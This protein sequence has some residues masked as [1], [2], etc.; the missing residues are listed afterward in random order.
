MRAHF[1]SDIFRGGLF[2][3][4]A[5]AWFA[6]LKAG[7][8]TPKLDGKYKRWLAANPA[9]EVAFE[10]QELAWELAG[11]LAKDDEIAVL[12]AEA[13][14][15]ARH[16]PKRA[17]RSRRLYLLSAVAAT[18]AV[19]TIGASVYLRLQSQT[20]QYTTAIGELRTVVLPDQSRM[21]LNTSTRVRVIYSRGERRVQLDQGEA[22]FLVA[23][24][25]SRPFQVDAARGTTRALGTEFNVLSVGNGTATVSVLSGR[26]EVLARN[27]DAARLML[28]RCVAERLVVP[29]ADIELALDLVFGPLFYRLLMGHA[30]ITRS[31]VDQLLDAVIPA[32]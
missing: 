22:T 10:R 17:E 20:L 8:I 31:F 27:R 21:V 9:N 28:E 5:P 14:L 7:P 13:Q 4:S 3:R 19:V 23:Q 29:P 18:L 26:V 30:P 1:L 2:R 32:L 15:V 24:D 25:S 16:P 6:H 12:L 11:E